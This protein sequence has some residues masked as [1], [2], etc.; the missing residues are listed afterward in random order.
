MVAA[1][2]KSD[3]CQETAMKCSC[4]KDTKSF[5]ACS[6]LGCNTVTVCTGCSKEIAG[7]SCEPQEGL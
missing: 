7:C 1:S 6:L 3:G 4:G 2:Q 5:E